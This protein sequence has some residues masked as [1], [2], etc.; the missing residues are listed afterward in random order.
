MYNN[1]IKNNDYGIR[2]IYTNGVTISHNTI[3][4]NDKDSNSCGIYVD[5]VS[6]HVMKHNTV[7]GSGGANIVLK[8]DTTDMVLSNNTVKDSGH[9][10]IYIG[11]SDNVSL[12]NNTIEDSDES[13]SDISLAFK[14]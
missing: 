14:L 6:S 3:K 9:D 10:G 7:T 2:I 13:F 12:W 11:D 4:N 8:S 5:I 1:T